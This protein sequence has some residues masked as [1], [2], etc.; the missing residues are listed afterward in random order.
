MSQVTPETR[1]LTA[2]DIIRLRDQMP[3]EQLREITN[4]AKKER[5]YLSFKV[6]FETMG[7]VHAY[8]N[9]YYLP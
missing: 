5:G 6:L 1:M 3:V 9:S 8:G 7:Y 4:R 2:T